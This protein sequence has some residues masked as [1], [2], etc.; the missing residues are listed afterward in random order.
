[1]SFRAC[2]RSTCGGMGNISNGFLRAGV[3]PPTS[4]ENKREK[5]REDK[6]INQRRVRNNKQACVMNKIVACD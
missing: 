4:R 2:E 6:L 3:S 5:V 1:M